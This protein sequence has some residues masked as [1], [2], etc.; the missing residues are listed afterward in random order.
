MSNA[1]PSGSA[2]SK[3]RG[4]RRGLDPKRVVLDQIDAVMRTMKTECL[5]ELAWSIGQLERIR[6]PS[7]SE[8]RID[9]IDRFDRTDKNGGASAFDFTHDVH[10]PT[11][12][13]AIDIERAGLSEHRTILVGHPSGCM[14]RGI[15]APQVGFHLDD[16]TR[17]SSRV[18]F[19][20]EMFA[21]KTFREAK[22]WLG[23]ERAIQT[24]DSAF[25]SMETSVAVFAGM[26]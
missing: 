26:H 12:V 8:H 7:M 1:N 2:D 25:R 10:A 15:V 19:M 13:D 18:G 11:G 22:R 9:P 14:T 17:Q 5:A 3:A 6:D 20:D 16:P 21:E 23:V 24:H 4:L